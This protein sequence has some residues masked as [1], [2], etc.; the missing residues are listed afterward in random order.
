MMGFPMLS[1][2]QV[3]HLF[4]ELKEPQESWLLPSFV[5]SRLTLL[6]TFL[7]ALWILRSLRMLLNM[8]LHL[9]T[10]NCVWASN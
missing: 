7:C 10:T 1:E 2:L 4:L 5:A 8:V 9:S 6:I 3:S